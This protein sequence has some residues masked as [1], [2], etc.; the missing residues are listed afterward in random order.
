MRI[1]DGSGIGYHAQVD[2]SNRLHTFSTMETELLHACRDGDAYNINTGIV[3]LTSANESGVLYV[4]NTST[5]HRLIITGIV[6]IL[7]PSTGGSS[8]DSTL[9]RM[10]KNPSTGTLISGA[11]AVDINSNRNFSSA[12]SLTGLAYKGS[13]GST[14][15]NGT[16]HIQSLV[17]AGS[18]TFF[19]IEEVLG[20]NNSIAVSYEPNDGNTSMKTMTAIICHYEDAF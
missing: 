19:A 4:K 7:S 11:T 2:S 15:T 18:R 12:K 17:S 13:E 5:T 16:Q 1:E 3:T 9:V 14:I 8:S 10:Y 6:C 20:Q